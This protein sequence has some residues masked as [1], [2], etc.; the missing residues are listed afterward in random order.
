MLALL[1]LMAFLHAHS[2]VM[3]C[4]ERLELEAVVV[5]AQ[6]RCAMLKFLAT[7]RRAFRTGKSSTG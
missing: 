6:V 4:I 5:R 1:A 7:M 3:M 2:K